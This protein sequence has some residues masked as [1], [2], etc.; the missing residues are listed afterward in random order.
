M[1][2]FINVECPKKLRVLLVIHL[3]IFQLQI[4]VKFLL[5]QFLD[6]LDIQVHEHGVEVEKGLDLLLV[7]HRVYAVIGVLLEDE[8]HAVQAE[9]G[10]QDAEVL[11]EEKEALNVQPS[12]ANS[13]EL[14]VF[15]GGLVVDAD[16]VVVDIG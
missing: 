16:V 10:L 5:L 6:G 1:R 2:L 12:W 3:R 8:D 11:A 4:I 15:L 9:D 13:V 14:G 7:R